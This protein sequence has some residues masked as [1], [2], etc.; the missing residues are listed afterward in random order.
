MAKAFLRI[1]YLPNGSF[2]LPIIAAIQAHPNA[3]VKALATKW[4]RTELSLVGASLSTKITMLGLLSRRLY[5]AL[6]PLVEELGQ[7]TDIETHLKRNAGW[8]PSQRNQ[9]Y[10]ILLEF[11]AYVFEFRSAYELLGKF[12]R[13]FSQEILATE[14]N[15]KDLIQILETR[16]IAMTWAVELKKHRILFF[17]QQAAWLAFNVSA[18]EPFDPEP[19]FL[20]D[21]DSDP[22]DTESTISL[23]QLSRIY[24]GFDQSLR[25]L[26]QWALLEIGKM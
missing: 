24:S 7:H 5:S 1:A 9:P 14:V 21:A 6:S 25:E 19:V 16:G 15:E 26:Q 12:M 11:D 13:L 4:N 3:E 17:H 2:V 22:R 10:E 8:V 23:L 20:M 18:T